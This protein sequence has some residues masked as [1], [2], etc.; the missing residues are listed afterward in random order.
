MG[1]SQPVTA[2]NHTRVLWGVGSTLHH[3][4]A[5]GRVD[6]TDG[7]LRGTGGLLWGWGS[8]SSGGGARVLALIVLWVAL[9]SL[10]HGLGILLV[11][12]DGPIED[13]VILE[14]LADKEIAE[15]LTEVRVVWLVVETKGA[16]VVQVDGKL[17][18]EAAAKDLGWGGHLLL[19]DAVVLLLL[20]SSLESLPWEGT[21]AE[22]K[23]D[24]SE[25][26][27]VIATGLL[28]ELV[29][30]CFTLD[31]SIIVELTDTQVS[32]DGSITGS[33]SQV[34][35][36][37]VW[38]VEVRLWVTVL[39][40]Q[41]EINHVDLVS[42]LANA[43]QEVVRLDIAVNE[44]LG[45]DVLNAGNEL[46]GEEQ[47]C[48]QGEL[49]VAEVE[50]ILEGRTKE[51]QDHGIVVAL[52]SEPA[53][54]WDTD[55]A[56]ERLVDASLILELWV[57]GL[58]RLELD[59]NL[60]SGDD[61]GTEVDVTEGAASNLASN[62]V[63]VTNAEILGTNVSHAARGKIWLTR[64]YMDIKGGRTDRGQH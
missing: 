7:W 5:R 43:H 17:V 12:V 13:V 1:N 4:A 11:L 33:S 32:I 30:G 24:V 56:S 64:V 18:R 45:V 44:R 57:L 20:S 37:S 3:L 9:V 51:I 58:D 38:D 63:L 22:I 29:N 52:G 50:Q 39:L 31:S 19:H 28:C 47:D 46:V 35:V 54:K 2:R 16:S 61:I 8:T 26:L 55:T 60:L 42:T 14:S 40:G 34:L 36:L 6:G 59:G 23:H 53:N 41:T 25:R 15:D 48:L 27:H 10:G 62:A 21:T 49:A